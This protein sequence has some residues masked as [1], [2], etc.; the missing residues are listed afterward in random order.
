M[1]A[2]YLS[3]N[4]PAPK[5]TARV[6]LIR[7]V[8]VRDR[9]RVSVRDMAVVSASVSIN[10]NNSSAGELMDK[11]RQLYNIYMRFTLTILVGLLP[12][13]SSTPSYFFTCQTL[14]VRSPYA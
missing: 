9:V 11:Y 3:V 12:S 7:K 2:R 1:S 14:L 5:L 13:K 4:S 10:K 8:K 6:R